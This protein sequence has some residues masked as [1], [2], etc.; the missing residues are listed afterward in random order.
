MTHPIHA[1]AQAYAHLSEDTLGALMSLMHDNARF[2]DPFHDVSGKEKI[3]SIFV[4]MFAT[5]HNPRFDIIAS[6]PHD[7]H[8]AYVRWRFTCTSKKGGI[9]FDFE[10]VSLIH[11]DDNGLV[12]QHID[13]WDAATHF[14]RRIPVIGGLFRLVA[15]AL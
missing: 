2:C 7:A 13:Y 6:T 15:R 1:Y 4:R 5:T 3:R 9:P 10:G 8:E 12:T 14:Y 11:F